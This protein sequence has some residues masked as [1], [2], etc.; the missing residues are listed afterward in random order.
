MTWA[1]S[2]K[3]T[4]NKL[5]AAASVL[6]QVLHKHVG[7]GQFREDG[8]GVLEGRNAGPSVNKL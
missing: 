1:G 5:Y 6:Q 7:G 4:W 3:G 8:S 2:T